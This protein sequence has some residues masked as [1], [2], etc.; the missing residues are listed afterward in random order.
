MAHECI[1]IDPAIM[2]GKP[3]IK[4]ARIKVETILMWLGKGASIDE[5]LN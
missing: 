1:T 3:V 4:G 5:V 2:V